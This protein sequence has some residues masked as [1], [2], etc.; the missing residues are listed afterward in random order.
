LAQSITSSAS[1]YNE[2]DTAGG[3]TT[4]VF[5]GSRRVDGIYVQNQTSF[6]SLITLQDVAGNIYG[7]IVSPNGISVNISWIAENGL[8]ILHARH[9]DVTVLHSAE[10]V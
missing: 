9:V 10:G 4:T 5:T 8:V 6:N 2:C 7:Y 3:C 1:T